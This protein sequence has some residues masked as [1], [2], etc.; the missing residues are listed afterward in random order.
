[1]V[2][3]D[4]RS[5]RTPQPMLLTSNGSLTPVSQ[6]TSHMS[7][8]MT[9][10][11][12]PQ[13]SISSQATS[14]ISHMQM[15]SQVSHM[16]RPS[17]VRDPLP[18]P[19]YLVS[20]TQPNGQL[21]SN[22]PPP[23]MTQASQMSNQMSQISQVSTQASVTQ[24]HAIA[25][26]LVQQS[27]HNSQA[28]LQRMSAQTRAPPAY[29]SSQTQLPHTA[30][31]VSRVS[32]SRPPQK[33]PAS[34]SP[35]LF[36]DQ[37]AVLQHSLT[38]LQN[39]RTLSK[40]SLATSTRPGDPERTYMNVKPV[41]MVGRNGQVMAGETSHV[42]SPRS[43]PGVGAR[44]PAIPQSQEVKQRQEPLYATI[45]GVTQGQGPPPVYE[46]S[47]GM[48]ANY[49]PASLYSNYSNYSELE[50]L[51][52]CESN[53]DD[54]EHTEGLPHLPHISGQLMIVK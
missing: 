10:Q 35:Y 21:Y 26:Q 39:T 2:H 47:G 44:T 12:A 46:D 43:D 29:S 5:S 48:Y 3:V 53:Y 24:R 37:R 16:S 28:Q 7:Y 17:V 34:Q 11:T 52:S 14:Q 22:T 45:L 30:S 6:L 9:S 23:Q 36:T 38:S 8:Q 40:P 41:A 42:Q 33:L 19:G 25:Q 20:G 27:L 18:V 32:Q 4:Q 1:M 51:R 15:P 50:M 54:E 13:L 31:H 49:A